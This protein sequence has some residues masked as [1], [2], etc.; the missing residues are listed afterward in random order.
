MTVI[1]NTK[2]QM[3]LVVSLSLEI[4]LECM[5]VIVVLICIIA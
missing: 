1:S 3:F 2:Y 4:A 5:S